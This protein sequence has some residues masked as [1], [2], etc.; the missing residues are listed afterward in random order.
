METKTHSEDL[1]WIKPI[2]TVNELNTTQNSDSGAFTDGTA[3]TPI[4]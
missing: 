4:S 2:L 3:N 1:I